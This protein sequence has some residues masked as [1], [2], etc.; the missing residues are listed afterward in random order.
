MR[1]FLVYPPMERAGI[2]LAG[3][4]LHFKNVTK[5][6]SLFP[7]PLENKRNDLPSFYFLKII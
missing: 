1:L 4:V 7:G 6:F 5:L 3:R 2:R